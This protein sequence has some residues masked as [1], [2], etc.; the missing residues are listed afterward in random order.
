MNLV[1][2][3]NLWIFTNGSLIHWYSVFSFI[4]DDKWKIFFDFHYAD[5]RESFHDGL[6]QGFGLFWIR[7]KK[8]EMNSKWL[9]EENRIKLRNLGRIFCWFWY[10][11]SCSWIQ[12]FERTV[13]SY[14]RNTKII[15]SSQNFPNM[16]FFLNI[17]R[18]SSSILMKFYE[19]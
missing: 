16:F 6:K 14:V 17:L 18:L 1:L 13:R 8:I 5:S 7:E 2:L 4:H 10:I 15:T 9:L 12:K 11:I 19:K 3:Q